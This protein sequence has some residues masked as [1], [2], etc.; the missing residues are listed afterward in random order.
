M[1]L[2]ELSVTLLG[3]PEIRAQGQPVAL[4]RRTNRCLLIFLAAQGRDVPRSDLIRFFWP[5]HSEDEARARLRETLSRLTQALPGCLL[6]DTQQAGLDFSRVEVDQLQFESL[7]SQA[8]VN[9]WRAPQDEPIPTARLQMLHEAVNL[10][11]GAHYLEGDPLRYFMQRSPDLHHRLSMTGQ[12]I[13]YH[14]LKILIHLSEHAQMLGNLDD[15]LETIH[16]ALLAD[17]VGVELNERLLQQMLELHLWGEIQ[18]HLGRLEVLYRRQSLPLPESLRQFRAKAEKQSKKLPVSE[19]KP[20]WNL[21]SN[22]LTPFVGREPALS[23]LQQD[24]YT[25]GG[26]LLLGESGQGKT[27][28][29]QEFYRR[30]RPRPRLL[31]ATCRS[32]EDILPFQPWID[33]L[34]SSIT[35]EEW[36]TIPSIWISQIAVLLPELLEIAPP[37]R[38]KGLVLDSSVPSGV[39]RS[40]LAEAIRQVLLILAQARRL[41]LCLDDAQWADEASLSTVAYLLERPPFERS[42]LILVSRLEEHS[43][44]MEALIS[45]IRGSQ[46]RNSQRARIIRIPYL[47]PLEIAQMVSLVIGKPP[48]QSLVEKLAAETGGNPLYLVETLRALMET[49]QSFEDGVVSN[50]PIT[51]SLRSLISAR[52]QALSPLGLGTL[53]AAAVLGSEFNP[54]LVASTSQRPMQDIILAIEELE[55]MQLIEGESTAPANLYYRFIHNSIREVALGEIRPLRRQWLE[56]QA[57]I[58]LECAHPELA[59]SQAALLAQHFEAGGEGARAFEYWIRAGQHARQLFSL[60]QADEAFAHAEALVALVAGLP[61]DRIYDLYTEWSEMA[62]EREDALTIENIS[63]RLSHTDRAQGSHLLQGTSL[64]LRCQASL[65]RNEYEIGL[66][67]ARLANERLA[68]TTHT[69]ARMEAHIHTSVFYYMLNQLEPAIEPLQAALRLGENAS[70]RSELRA[71]ANAHYQA[72]LIQTLQGWPQAALPHALH[73]LDDYILLNRSYGKVMAYSMLTFALYSLGEYDKAREYS[74]AGLEI[75]Q[76]ARAERML[77]YLRSYRAFIELVV[78]NLDEGL[79]NA[80]EAVEI[81]LRLQHHEISALGYRAI[82]DALSFIY[83]HQAAATYYEKALQISGGGFFYLDSVYRLG[84]QLFYL[85]KKAD[86]ITLIEQ[87]IALAA[88]GGVAVHWLMAQACNLVVLVSQNQREQAAAVGS[89][90]QAQGKER[91]LPII[92]LYGDLFLGNLA[93][94]NGQLEQAAIALQRTA[95]EAE[96]LSMAWVA[97]PAWR[98]LHRALRLLNKPDEAPRFHLEQLLERLDTQIQSPLLHPALQTYKSVILKGLI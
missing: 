45:H 6:I 11:K 98:G 62:Y 44:P 72:A 60:I 43:H 14:H 59:D 3:T 92:R 21:R 33:L 40:R 54:A 12:Q 57:A 69:A 27:R 71:R 74:K 48:H 5:H 8:G 95:E 39:A 84:L 87:G 68:L 91:G 20:A 53:Q 83:D 63:D 16:K 94:E 66:E 82:G 64:L 75:A 76:N 28:L 78:G 93:M 15:C 31:L 77:G 81:G 13:E 80:E 89:V 32:G 9:T 61:D 29:V 46:L 24:Y 47:N 70:T 18:E 2:P 36:S 41:L 26:V 55:N 58:S 88:A 73:S 50:I 35:Q 65:I 96:R 49:P 86:A 37:G 22:L 30:A 25:G 52:T 90:L 38:S 17:Q 1:S 51:L 34:R 7:V 67:Y 4:E 56:R 10:W 19:S 42:L 79:A 97:I 85:G 23:E